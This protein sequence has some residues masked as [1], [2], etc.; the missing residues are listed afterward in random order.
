MDRRDVV[1][2]RSRSPLSALVRWPTSRAD[3]VIR[4]RRWRR[5]LING[6]IV[7]A[8]REAANLAFSNA[9]L[10]MG[11]VLKWGA[12]GRRAPRALGHSPS[13]DKTRDEEARLFR[14]KVRLREQLG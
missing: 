8:C 1:T 14:V 2:S 12:G 3:W 6:A 10:W 11:L 13:A 9:A 4:E 7:L 5:S